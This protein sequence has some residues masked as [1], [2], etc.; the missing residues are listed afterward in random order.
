VWSYWIHSYQGLD[1]KEYD[2]FEDNKK[3]VL[4]KRFNSPKVIKNSFYQDIFYFYR[5]A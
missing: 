3:S 5:C 1:L 2:V 4:K